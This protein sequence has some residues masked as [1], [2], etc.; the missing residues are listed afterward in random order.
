[1]RKFPEQRRGEFT[2]WSGDPRRS[3]LLA[4]YEARQ[5]QI[6]LRQMVLAC[7]IVT[8]SVLIWAAVQ[9]IQAVL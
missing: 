9:V 6:D 4:E 3:V 2:S 8:L 1:M 7:V 5:R